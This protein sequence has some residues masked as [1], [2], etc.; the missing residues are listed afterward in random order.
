M[1]PVV[2]PKGGSASIFLKGRLSLSCFFCRHDLTVEQADFKLVVILLPLPPGAGIA[3]MNPP[4]L[5]PV[6]LGI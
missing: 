1:D 5:F 6:V 2:D 3:A 4:Q